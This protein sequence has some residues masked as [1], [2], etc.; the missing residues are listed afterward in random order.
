L[1]RER[2]RYTDGL[3]ATIRLH[4]DEAGGH[5]AK[6]PLPALDLFDYESVIADTQLTELRALNLMRFTT[7]VLEEIILKNLDPI[8]RLKKTAD[9]EYLFSSELLLLTAKAKTALQEKATQ[10]Y[11]K[12]L[13]NPR[14]LPPS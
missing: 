1:Y 4:Q 6:G 8:L 14:S 11:K 9:C 13:A 10:V 3:Q 12:A 5:G 7:L 2:R